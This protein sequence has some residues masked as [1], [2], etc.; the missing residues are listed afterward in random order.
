MELDELKA[1]W[2]DYGRQL[3]RQTARSDAL[4]RV[5]GLHGIG[6]RVRLLA[7]AQWLQLAIGL[8]FSLWGGAAW[9][10]HWG[11]WH[12]VAYGLALHGYGLA[13]LLTAAVQ[14]RRIGAIDYAGPIA[15]SQQAIVRLRRARLRSDRILF[16]CGGVMWVPALGLLLHT[17]GV[18]LWVL[19]PAVVL[20]NLLAGLAISVAL[21]VASL[22]WPAWFE[23]SAQH[24]RLAEIERDL[25]GLDE[26]SPDDDGRTRRGA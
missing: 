18:D 13:L 3:E 7:G 20:A 17:A 16:A 25:R 9:T 15:D 26:E 1:A 23:R 6:R 19:R 11:S 22:R 10:D 24:R 12:L 2:I 5:R 4:Q 21:V 14:L 8:L